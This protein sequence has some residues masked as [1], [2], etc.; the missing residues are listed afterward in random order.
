MLDGRLKQIFVELTSID[1]VSG[2]EA[3]IADYIEHFVKN[4]G[5]NCYRDNADKLSMGNTGNVIVPILGGGEFFLAAHM[6]T[7]RSTKNL[8]HQFLSDR[9]TS[10]GTTPLGVD[11]RGGL[12]SILFALE[13]AVESKKLLPCTL[14][15]TVCEETSMAGSI[16]Y[17]PAQGIKYG[18][19][20]DSFMS[21][22]CFVS[23]TCGLIDFE[24]VIRGKASHAGISPE[25]GVNAIMIAAE[26]M[27]HF[28]FGRLGEKETANIGIIKGGVGTN[29]VCDEVF[30][31]GEVR[32]GTIEKGEVMIH[33]IIE[34]FKQ[35][36]EKYGGR[37][38]TK[39]N[40]DFVPYEIHDEDLPFKHFLKAASS[41]GLAATPMK[42]M[43]GSDA[44]SL[45]AKEIKTVNLG[46]GAQNPHGNDEFI[47]YEDF[48]NAAKIAYQ[49][50]T[51][52]LE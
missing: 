19:T 35:A 26:A 21:P 1:A 39:Y 42:S 16:T 46:V 48:I 47:L 3:P 37:L 8:K 4:L 41:I 32:S 20:F 6:D 14:L 44:N 28:P 36:C 2:S 7:P 49:L 22:A 27:T 45:N 24:F 52:H 38:E 10:D 12:S 9:I 11:D 23:E 30:M 18:F 31:R 15:F 34:D 5:L 13:K 33:K 43:G 25:K 50:L 40:W 29:V 17:K 51:T